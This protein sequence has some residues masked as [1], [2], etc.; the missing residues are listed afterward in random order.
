[1]AEDL[2]TR[3]IGYRTSRD[4]AEAERREISERRFTYLDRAILR[5]K[6]QSAPESGLSDFVVVK[7]PI[8]PELADSAKSQAAHIVG[9]LG[10]LQRMG[11]AAPA[12]PNA[13][14]LR[15]DLEL[16][17]RA[18]QRSADRQRTLAAHGVPVSDPRLP[19]EVLDIRKFT[20]V[21]GRILVHGQDEQ[22]G[23]SG[24]AC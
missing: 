9:R 3:Q 13:W 20:A 11:L 22:S 4:A 12:G 19:I 14:Q 23:R 24:R 1:M 10:V 17:L 21:E 6:D 7:N 2:C 18:M 8:P 5:Q 16:V 15:R